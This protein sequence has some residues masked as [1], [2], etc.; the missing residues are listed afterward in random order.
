MKRVR[1][2]RDCKKE[3]LRGKKRLSYLGRERKRGREKGKERW[4]EGGREMLRS[5][6][7]TM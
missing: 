3:G 6:V 5:A 7:V 1:E 2:E 4:R